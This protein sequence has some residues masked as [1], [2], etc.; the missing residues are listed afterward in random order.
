MFD[1]DR[2]K[3]NDGFGNGNVVYGMRAM[4]VEQWNME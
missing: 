3:W 2:G 1:L 4:V